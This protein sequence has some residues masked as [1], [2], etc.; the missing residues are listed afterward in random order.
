MTE[1][2]IGPG[3][4]S[5]GSTV[6]GEQA[7]DAQGSAVRGKPSFCRKADRQLDMA[8]LQMGLGSQQSHFGLT[9]M[10]L[11]PRPLCNERKFETPDDIMDKHNLD[12]TELNL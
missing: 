3:S 8:W 1:R 12:F 5:V 4:D 11:R 6:H 7:R 2:S 10:I 9:T